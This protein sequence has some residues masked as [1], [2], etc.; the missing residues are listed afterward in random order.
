[1][2]TPVCAELADAQTSAEILHFIFSLFVCSRP[3]SKK[4]QSTFL[5]GHIASLKPEVETQHRV[6]SQFVW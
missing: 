1:M 6:E 2:S 4:F 5:R 3:Q